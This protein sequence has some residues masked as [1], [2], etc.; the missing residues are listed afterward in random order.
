MTI[1][2]KL[3][4]AGLAFL[5]KDH[6]PVRIN[7]FLSTDEMAVEI[8]EKQGRDQGWA[9]DHTYFF[10]MAAKLDLEKYRRYEAHMKQLIKK[11]S[12][13]TDQSNQ[14]KENFI[15]CDCTIRKG[16]RQCRIRKN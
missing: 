5:L 8:W 3:K 6:L 9:P 15:Q 14:D 10:P 13:G 11:N 12:P 1:E 2:E 4:V 7:T 16:E